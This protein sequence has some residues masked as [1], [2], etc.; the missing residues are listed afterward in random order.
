MY[1][2]HPGVI[3]VHAHMHTRVCVHTP[4]THVHTHIHACRHART[5]GFVLSH[6]RA[7]RIDVGKERRIVSLGTACRAVFQKA[8]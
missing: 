5:P 2:M 4:Y 8:L 3:H 1:T 6:S 7:R